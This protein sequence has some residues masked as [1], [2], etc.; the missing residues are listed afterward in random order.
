MGRL[1][2]EVLPQTRLE[3][4][5]AFTGLGQWAMDRGQCRTRSD[6]HI[7]TFWALRS[8][9]KVRETGGEI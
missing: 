8:L 2:R 4:I 9:T 6:T 7:T 5:V 3:V 1:V